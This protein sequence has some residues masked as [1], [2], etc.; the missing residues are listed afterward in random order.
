MTK[1]ES[2]LLS[3]VFEKTM[4]LVCIVDKA[5]Y[6]VQINPAVESTLGYTKEELFAQPVAAF[7]HPDDQKRTADAREGLLN[8]FPLLN[9]QNRYVTRQGTIVWLQWTSVY[10]PE[11]EIVFAIAKN[12]TEKKLEELETIANYLKYKELTRQFKGQVEKDRAYFATE[13][14]EELG[15]LATVIKMD[16]EWAGSLLSASDPE[17][18]KRLAQ[19]ATTIQL[20]I[21]KI[22]KL[23]YSISPLPIA[24]LGLNAVLQDLCQEFTRNTN[25]P[26]HYFCSFDEEQLSQEIK[27]DLFRICQESLTQVFQQREVTQVR[28]FLDQHANKVTLSLYS[29][30]KSAAATNTLEWE[31][32]R[33]RASSINGHL[34]VK[35]DDKGTAVY[36]TV[37]MN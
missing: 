21:D 3:S 27:V 29:D 5:G 16:Y 37:T 14:H 2:L 9:F 23:S 20:L 12:I 1:D 34:Y 13:L 19:G 4:D 24:E 15:Q 11:Q 28:V 30:G 32:L 6:F 8:Q 17:T 26:C 31:Q 35:H 7:I 10:I 22:R 18:K 36:L 25:V 33:S